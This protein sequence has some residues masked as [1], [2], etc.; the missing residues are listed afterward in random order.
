MEFLIT[1]SSIFIYPPFKKKRSVI[2]NYSF[3]TFSKGRQA[4]ALTLVIVR[5]NG[6]EYTTNGAVLFTE[7][8]LAGNMKTKPLV[9][10][11]TVELLQ[12]LSSQ[13]RI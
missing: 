13:C 10:A 3:T 1:P 9:P 4:T 7:K 2:H 11:K 12:R 5:Y 6:V 8:T